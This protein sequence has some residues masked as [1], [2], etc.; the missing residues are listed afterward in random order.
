MQVGQGSQVR[1]LRIKPETKGMMSQQHCVVA[2][3]VDV[4]TRDGGRDKR[5]ALKL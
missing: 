5:S 2:T 1:E 3:K 4:A